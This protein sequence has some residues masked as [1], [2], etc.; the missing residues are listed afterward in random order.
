MA[1]GNLASKARVPVPTTVHAAASDAR[2]VDQAMQRAQV[3]LERADGLGR[4]V[5]GGGRKPPLEKWPPLVRNLL[6]YAP[7]GIV[8]LVLLLILNGV[9][10]AVP[11]LAKWVVLIGVLLPAGVAGGAILLRDSMM[12]APMTRDPEQ[13]N[14]KLAFVCCYLGMALF[15]LV[16]GS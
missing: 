1:L 11:A 16:I 13:R 4:L 6:V 8:T 15:F 10:A 14:A 12:T 3:A 7:A 9:A 5:G 2:T